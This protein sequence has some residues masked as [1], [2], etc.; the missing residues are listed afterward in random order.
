MVTNIN[1]K[2]TVEYPSIR[3]AARGLNSNQS[4]IRRRLNKQEL[5]Q[6]IYNN[7]ELM[8][9]A[10]LNLDRVLCLQLIVLLKVNLFRN[11]VLTI[12]IISYIYLSI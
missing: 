7:L 11:K 8:Q 3:E 9:D 12:K 6:N 10:S 5:F 1:T 2:E 4:T